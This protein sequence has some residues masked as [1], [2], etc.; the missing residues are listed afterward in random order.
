MGSRRFRAVHLSGVLLIRL[1][2]LALGTGP[3]PLS[4]AQ[5]DSSIQGTVSDSSGGA[6][7]GVAIRIKNVDTGAV[8]NLVTDEAGRYNAAA[9]PAGRYEVGAEKTGFRSEDKTGISLVLGQRETTDLVLQV[10]DVGQTVHVESAPTVVAVTTEDISG[11]VGERQVKDLPLNGRSYDQ[12]L[13]LNPGIVNYPSQRA[14]GIG[15]SN[16]VVGNMFSA[17]GHRPQDNLFLLNGVEFTG[18]SQIDSTPG[19][20]SGQLL[21]V[22]A[23]REFSV[24][25]DTYGAEYGKRPGAQVNIVTASGTNQ[26]H[27]DTYEFLRNSAL[28]ARNFF[29]LP[30]IPH[31]ER[32]VFGGSLGGPIRKD[33]TFLFANYEGFRQGLGLSDVTLVPDANARAG[34]LPCAALTTVTASCNAS[35]PPTQVVLGQGVANLLN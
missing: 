33:K 13:T 16:S 21:G 27:G 34:K 20:V 8:R 31:F 24:V 10:G 17:S 18:A 6:V 2:A 35:T 9:L 15:T 28:D 11:L 5:G 14:G 3:A 29:D 26:F 25:K 7:P 22:D 23:V 4:F 30:Q 32:N 12:L 1:L 19:G